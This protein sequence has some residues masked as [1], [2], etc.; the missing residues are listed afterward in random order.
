M[1]AG[2]KSAVRRLARTSLGR[3]LVHAAVLDD[4]AT[5]RFATVDRWPPSLEGFEDLAFLFS[6]NQLNHGIA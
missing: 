5:L 6:S 4:P 3:N 2:V 1:R